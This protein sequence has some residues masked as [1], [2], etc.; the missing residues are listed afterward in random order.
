MGAYSQ[1]SAALRTGSLTIHYPLT[2]N[3]FD[4]REIRNYSLSLSHF[5]PSL[6]LSSPSLPSPSPLSPSPSFTVGLSSL[7]PPSDSP[8]SYRSMNATPL[9]LPGGRYPSGQISYPLTT[10]TTSTSGSGTTAGAF[11]PLGHFTPYITNP[12]NPTS[13]HSSP[14]LQPRTGLYGHYQVLQPMQ[15]SYLS[16]RPTPRGGLGYGGVM[17]TT[18]YSLQPP[19]G[20]YS[21]DYLQQEQHRTHWTINQP[22][23][24]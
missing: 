1:S 18:S 2:I 16:P 4:I 22:N 19:G 13:Y 9:S 21:E 10:S 12:N 23:F 6:A 20:T 14:S 5:P 17:P 11:P 7:Y 8:L 3:I 15:P 24:P